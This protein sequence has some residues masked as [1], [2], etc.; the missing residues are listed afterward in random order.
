MNTNIAEYLPD[1][2][3]VMISACYS[4]KAQLL[5][6]SCVHK[7]SPRSESGA[8]LLMR[9]GTEQQKNK[10]HRVNGDASAQMSGAQQL[11][12]SSD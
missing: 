5:Q 4:V 7:S 12:S 8:Q 1:V 10:Q 6:L 11:A 3:S 9:R 2:A